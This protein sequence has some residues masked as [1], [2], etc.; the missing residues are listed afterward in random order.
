MLLSQYKQ[1]IIVNIS[2]ANQ[3]HGGETSSCSVQT[4]LEH[5]QRLNM[6][7]V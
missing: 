3:R 6:V 5:Q 2:N 1:Q 4:E 7:P